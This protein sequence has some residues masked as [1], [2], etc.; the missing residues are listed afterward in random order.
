MTHAC[1]AHG[2]TTP[3][4][5]AMFMCRRHWHSLRKPLRD[6]IWREYRSGQEPT[7]DPSPRYLAVQRLA[8]AEVAFKPHD[9]EAARVAEDQCPGHVGSRIFG[10]KFCERC[11]THVDSL[12]PPD[13]GEPDA[14]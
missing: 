11:G 12:R 13:D 14:G 6:A 9:E 1:H 3:V 8:I 7:K 2:C 4:P 5:P 10:M